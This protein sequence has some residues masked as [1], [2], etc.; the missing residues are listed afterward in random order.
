M[1]Q[2]PQS[3][4]ASEC[5]FCSCTSVDGRHSSAST[6][7]TTPVDQISR[8]AEDPSMST[9]GVDS[10]YRQPKQS[11]RRLHAINELLQTERDYVNDL[12]HLVEVCFEALLLQ[13]WIPQ[14][15]KSV[16]IRNASDIL[17]L[18]RRFLDALE[19]AAPGSN[20]SLHIAN[21][22]LDMGPEFMLYTHYCDHHS[23]AWY[24]CSEY[25]TRPDWACFL[26]DCAI[27]DSANEPPFLV[28]PLMTAKRLHFD[29]YLIKAT[30]YLY[31]KEKPVQ[32][33]CRYQLLIKEIIRYTAVGA[34]E[35]GP[36]N[37]ALDI[38]KQ[39]V[40]EIDRRKHERDV[41]ERTERFVKRLDGDWRI[42][43]NHVS[44][45]GNLIIAGAL[46]V[47]YTALGQSV[48]KPRYLGCFVF[49][50]YLIL[51]RPKKAT[52]YEPK[53]WFPLDQAEFEDLLDIEG[54]REN[55]FIVR[56]KKHT[57]A[58]SATCPQEKQLW[59][60]KFKHTI[61]KA[62]NKQQGPSCLPNAENLIISSLAGVTTKIPH[63]QQPY[64]RLSRSFTNILDMTIS[65]TTPFNNSSHHAALRRSVSIDHLG[66]AT[67]ESPPF[68][69]SPAPPASKPKNTRP[70]AVK[71]R[72]SVDSAKSSK[73]D[74]LRKSRN[75]S[76]TYLK[77][78]T[79]EAI[80][81]TRRRPNSLDLLATSAMTNSSGSGSS[82]TGNMIGKMSF[83][84]KNNHHH[85]LRMAA[86]HK[87]RDVCTQDYLS[88]RAWYM[89][90]KDIA[91][92]NNSPQVD[93]RKRKSAP[94]MR[95]SASSF[96][97]IS[98]RRTSDAGQLRQ[99]RVECDVQSTVSSASSV[100]DN[101]PFRIRGTSRTPSQISHL[102]SSSKSRRPSDSFK[103]SLS[104]TERSVNEEDFADQ[105]SSSSSTNHRGGSISVMSTAYAATTM[106]SRAAGRARSSDSQ[107]CRR[108]RASSPISS[109]ASIFS[110]MDRTISNYSINVGPLKSSIKS[111]FVDKMLQKLK[112]RNHQ[113]NPNP[114]IPTQ[115]TRNSIGSHP[116]ET[117]GKIPSYSPL[118][119]ADLQKSKSSPRFGNNN[120][121]NK[122][123]AKSP[124][125]RWIKG[126]T[127]AKSQT[128]E[129]AVL[130]YVEGTD[131]PPLTYASPK[132]TVTASIITTAT[133]TTTQSR[134]GWK[135]K[136]H[137]IR[138]PNLK[139]K[140]R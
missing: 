93:L 6:N 7:C 137:A 10:E 65:G 76:E 94:F 45:L 38:M 131:S 48:A 1:E 114:G 11:L 104:A 128:L 138:Q 124:L 117:T 132:P 50:T 63:P 105:R 34:A 91:N 71:K 97:V 122:T 37:K 81:Q 99:G 72:Y 129:E 123:K 23:E 20:Q 108:F 61:D 101:S 115:P 64:I 136:L 66:Q 82:N 125:F 25:R 57:F 67:E 134:L 109:S 112:P 4:G 62:K 9:T 135:G 56:C 53:H 24:L 36:L 32:R 78:S 106:S 130:K 21:V 87:L 110:G 111:A 88:S 3:P 15:H 49:P 35:Q 139:D 5:S 51:V 127:A 47:T 85:T 100:D 19:K 13:D 8:P 102:R 90:E 98:L 113:G 121:N 69:S 2:Q 77:P 12:V 55:S 119:F 92:N 68:P 84:I 41:I 80:G 39:I 70:A 18:H 116:E 22:F 42:S 74:I 33:I 43:K 54:Q 30:P 16:I 29:D 59:V 26:K 103:C 14:K 126:D 79:L 46:E 120:N 31:G 95:S 133:T 40:S 140:S 89:R 73:K 107:D 96:S 17:A 118:E 60:Q 58:F 83:Q 86:D 75:H 44:N 27:M 28:E 52:N